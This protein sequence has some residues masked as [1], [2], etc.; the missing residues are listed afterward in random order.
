M[1]SDFH[2][3]E[4]TARAL[5][6]V[7]CTQARAQPSPLSSPP[8]PPSRCLI[9]PSRGA[10]LCSAIPGGCPP[11]GA[12]RGCTRA[13]AHTS[14]L[15]VCLQSS[16]AAAAAKVINHSIKIRH[17]SHK[18]HPETEHIF[19][20]RFWDRCAQ[21]PH[22]PHD[23]GSEGAPGRMKGRGGAMRLSS[24]SL[25]VQILHR[26]PLRMGMLT[27][28]QNYTEPAGWLSGMSGGCSEGPVFGPD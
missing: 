25:S 9:P 10:V 2:V 22:L 7:Y 14:A 26:V 21:C 13:L 15:C 6:H 19:D 16:T 18:V 5:D 20:D 28:C 24:D 3:H 1:A 23:R 17:M 27:Q 11:T 8:P 4:G 12:C